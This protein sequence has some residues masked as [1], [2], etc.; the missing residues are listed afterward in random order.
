MSYPEPKY[1]GE[2]GVIDADLRRADHPP[3]ITQANGGSVQYLA[4]G[5]DTGGEFGLYRWNFAPG[6]SGPDPHF[7]KTITESF[8]VLDGAVR[9]YDGARWIDGAAGDFLRIPPGGIHGFRN[10][11]DEPASML[12]L[13]TPG[14]PREQYFEWLA[15]IGQGLRSL[16]DDERREFY[17]RHDTFWS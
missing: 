1:T 13:F 14:A 8:F 2:H 3:E 16:S 11:S 7:H 5:A 6:R 12:I 15:E 10:E 9:L 4:T 17:L